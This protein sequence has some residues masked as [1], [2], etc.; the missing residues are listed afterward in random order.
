MKA[1]VFSV[2]NKNVET[3]SKNYDSTKKSSLQ[4]ILQPRAL[5]KIQAFFKNFFFRAH[6][7]FLIRDQNLKKK[8]FSFA[9]AI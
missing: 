2:I 1:E 3:L 7:I 5:A 8:L 9:K 4:P 6:E